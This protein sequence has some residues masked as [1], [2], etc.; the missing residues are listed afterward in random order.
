MANSNLWMAKLRLHG[1]N[2]DKKINL[3]KDLDE[4]AYEKLFEEERVRVAQIQV[5][6]AMK[7]AE[8]MHRLSR[9]QSAAS[10]E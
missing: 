10:S 3:P 4:D 8:L 5:K 7:T 6:Q 1:C 9:E 2:N